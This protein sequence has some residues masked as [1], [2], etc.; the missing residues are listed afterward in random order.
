MPAPDALALAHCARVGDRIRTEIE[1]AGGSISFRRY[2]EM[3]LYEPGLGYYSAG[4][5]KFGEG[6]DFVTAPELS[7]LFSMCVARQCAEILRTLGG[8]VILECGAGSGALA[9][10]LLSEL[11]MTGELPEEYW[12]LEISAELR[13]RQRE[14][15]QSRLGRDAARVRWLEQPPDTRFDGIIFAN[16]LL[17][18]LPVHRL[19]LNPGE[20]NELRVTWHAGRFDWLRSPAEPRLESAARRIVA[21]LPEALPPGYR[22][23]LNPDLRAWLATLGRGLR[24][25]V[26][27]FLDY[28]YLRR[29]YYHPQRRDGTLLC[30]YRHRVHADP[31]LYPGLQDISAAVDF[32]AVAEAGAFCELDLIG[33]TTQAHFLAGCDLGELLARHGDCAGRERVEMQRQARILTLPGEMGEQIKAM[34][35]GRGLSKALCGFRSAD[36]RSRLQGSG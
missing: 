18:A 12:I 11:S 32:N 26:V 14:S 22:T 24:S 13:E 4:M 8:G 17:D 20:V 5:R 1:R 29:E 34:A 10:D 31:F 33:F 30:H 7:P 2:M 27:L 36:H 9:C 3:A 28:G 23:E 16:E 35:L 6:G 15:I 19:E 21:K 25:G